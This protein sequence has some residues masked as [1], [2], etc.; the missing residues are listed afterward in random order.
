MNEK[1]DTHAAYDAA[2]IERI[3]QSSNNKRPHRAWPGLVWIL[4]WGAYLYGAFFATLVPGNGAAYLYAMA[5]L[6]PV[7]LL[8]FYIRRQ[9]DPLFRPGVLHIVTL[10]APVVGAAFAVWLVSSQIQAL[11]Y[12]IENARAA[13]ESSALIASLRDSRAS[14]VQIFQQILLIGGSTYLA[15]GSLALL[16]WVWWPGSALRNLNWLHRTPIT[17]ALLIIAVLA[18]V[19][20]WLRV[21]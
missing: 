7:P 1:H 15:G 3:Q 10:L 21:P 20:L 18:A 2:I 19:H 11:D 12:L 4:P 13:S 14:T 17:V 8:F 9:S 6:L 5:V 16:A